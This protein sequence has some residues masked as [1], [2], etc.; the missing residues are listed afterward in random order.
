MKFKISHRM[1]P[2]FILGFVAMIISVIYQ[3][4]GQPRYEMNDSSTIMTVGQGVPSPADPSVPEN[5]VCDPSANN[6]TLTGGLVAELYYMNTTKSGSATTVMNFF[7]PTMAIKSPKQVFFSQ[8]NT[9]VQYFDRGFVTETGSMIKDDAGKD[10]HEWFALKYFSELRISKIEDEGFYEF[11]SLS[12]DG[13]IFEAFVDG[14]WKKIISDDGLHPPKLGCSSSMIELKKNI[15]VPIRVYYYQGPGLL[16]SNVLH[17]RKSAGVARGDSE[18]G[19][20]N[21]FFD[22]VTST[23]QQ[24]YLNLLSRGWSVVPASAFSLPGSVVNPCLN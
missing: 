15:G 13:H 4:C 2:W 8:I 18:C 3:N 23:P 21:N 17:W 10:L 6:T 5:I 22:P 19:Q 9:P 1:R 20:T 16:I 7:E 11:A 14:Q 24:P 12:D